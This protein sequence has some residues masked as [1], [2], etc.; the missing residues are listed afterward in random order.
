MLN[1]LP[2]EGMRIVRAGWAG[3]DYPTSLK[4]GFCR[5]ARFFSSRRGLVKSVSNVAADEMRELKS[6]PGWNFFR[7]GSSESP[8]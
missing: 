7:D 5:L 6:F 2:A 4:R 3:L 1:I 8:E